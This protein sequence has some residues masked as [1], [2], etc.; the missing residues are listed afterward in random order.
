MPG[1]AVPL[2]SRQPWL[3]AHLSGEGKRLVLGV[4]RTHIRL[5]FG[6]KKTPRKIQLFLIT[7][8]KLVILKREKKCNRLKLQFP[9][10]SLRNIGP[11]RC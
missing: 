7:D 2:A 11:V 4:E 3:Q 6:R 8:K 10:Y 5:G 1:Q 9:R